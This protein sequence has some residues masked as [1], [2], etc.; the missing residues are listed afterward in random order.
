VGASSSF[1]VTPGRIFEA[2]SSSTFVWM[3]PAASMA[4][5]SAG[6]FLMI[7]T[8]SSLRGWAGVAHAACARASRSP[9]ERESSG[10]AGERVAA[11]RRA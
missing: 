1:V 7:T 11:G 2:I 8:P 9:A 6:D 10:L 3:A 5:I 4:S